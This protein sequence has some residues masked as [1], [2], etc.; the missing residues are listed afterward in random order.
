M[1]NFTPANLKNFSASTLP[2]HPL[3][4]NKNI[5]KFF[6]NF[7]KLEN[8]IFYFID[9]LSYFQHSSDFPP[10]ENFP[11]QRPSII[12]PFESSALSTRLPKIPEDPVTPDS[13]LTPEPE[14]TAVPIGTN[15]T[16]QENLPPSYEDTVK[17]DVTQF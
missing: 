7:Y 10:Q 12:I 16:K 14:I 8:F 2:T 15:A 13:P 9:R 11:R 4:A 1:R 3:G 17:D 5:R 6:K